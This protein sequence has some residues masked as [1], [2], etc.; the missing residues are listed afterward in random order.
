MIMIYSEKDT[1]LALLTR[2][3]KY[4]YISEAHS[5]SLEDSVVNLPIFL[6]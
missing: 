2:L 4:R 6:I 3:A 5:G 1:Q